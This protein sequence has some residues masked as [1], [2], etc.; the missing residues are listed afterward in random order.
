MS[1]KSAGAPSQLSAVRGV[2]GSMSRSLWVGMLG[3]AVALTI[4]PAAMA[5]SVTVSNNR[6]SVGESGNEHNQ[7]AVGYDAAGDFYAVTDTAGIRATG[8]CTQ[9]NATTA[10]CPGAGI[11]AISVSAGSRS[12]ILALNSSDPASVEATLDGG[13][14]DDT[15]IGGPANDTLGGSSGRDSLDG[16]GGADELFGGSGPDSVSY[17]ERVAGVAVTVGSVNDDGNADDQSGSQRDSVRRDVEIVTGGLA[18]DLLVG[19]GSSEVLEGGDGDDTLIGQHGSDTL[20]GDAGSDFMLGGDGPD[21]L[22]GWIGLDRMRGESGNDLL[23]GGPDD[24]VLKGGFGIDRLR[25]KGG[26]DRLLARDGTPDL[27]INCGQGP[28]GLERAKRDKRLDPRPKS[29]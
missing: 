2:E 6:V 8:E 4:A 22:R 19:D 5:S 7:I 1:G 15:L 26:A 21:A 3:I 24:D 20:L 25:G 13:P 9:V 16:A 17:A 10:T 27:K 11:R 29:C 18:A 12:D 14:G 23:A 28:N